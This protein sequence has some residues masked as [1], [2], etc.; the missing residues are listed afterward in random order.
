MSSNGARYQLTL[1]VRWVYARRARSVS[2]LDV[3]FTCFRQDSVQ[4]KLGILAGTFADGSLSLY[5]V[6]DPRQIQD[7]SAM[8]EDNSTPVCGLYIHACFVE[9]MLMKQS[10]Q[11]S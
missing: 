5:A 8:S 3:Q 11:N 2:S 1:S 4:G 7:A 9:P 10:S 6:P